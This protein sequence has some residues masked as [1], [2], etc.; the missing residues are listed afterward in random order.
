MII[1]PIKFTDNFAML[2]SQMVWKTILL[3]LFLMAVNLSPAWAKKTIHMYQ[4]EVKVMDIGNVERVAIGNPKIISNSLLHPGQLVM[5]ANSEGITSMH[6]WL[7]NGS[8]MDFD[9]SVKEKTSFDSYSEIK[10]LLRSTP[11]IKVKK[12]G[13][14][15]VLS[16]T[17]STADKEIFDRIIKQ[18]PDAL[19]LV[20]QGNPFQELSSLFASIPNLKVRKIGKN[21]VLSGEISN[22]YANIISQVTSKFPNV[23]NMTRSQSTVAGKMVYMEVK[24]MEVKKSFSETV[25]INWSNLGLIGPSLEFGW[26]GTARSGTIAKSD[27]VPSGIK[28]SSNADFS[29]GTGYVGIATGITSTI[30]LAEETGDAVLLANPRLSARSG[31]KAEFLSGGE[32]PLPVTNDSGQV[33]VEFK[34]YGIQLLIEPVVDDLGN[35]LAHVDT[36]VSTVDESV[37]VDGIPGIASRTTKADISMREN[38][39]MVI[40]GLLSDDISNSFDK[41]KWLANL[42]ILGPLFRSK[43]FQTKRTELLIFVTPKI[44]DATSSVNMEALKKAAEINQEYLKLTEGVDLLE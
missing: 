5:L 33:T 28:D 4:G 43:S 20:T 25:G 38:Q 18:F 6:L 42:P 40:G 34:K 21:T 14:L 24:I 15:T 44:Y 10:Q 41:V 27:N 11:G 13:E 7:E 39:T 12:V 35:I 26:Q 22:Q 29:A 23:I 31:G 8:E 37:A 9:V 30:N 19:N 17:I 1:Q 16:G 32:Y 36:E 2:K 3:I